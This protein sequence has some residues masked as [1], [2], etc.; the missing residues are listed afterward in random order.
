MCGFGLGAC[1]V[2]LGTTQASPLGLAGQ[3]R[4][5]Y[6]LRRVQNGGQVVGVS[7]E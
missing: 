6:R 2:P 7:N 1:L 4:F 5:T 3:L